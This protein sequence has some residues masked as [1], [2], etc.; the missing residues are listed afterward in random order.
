MS[1]PVEWGTEI[2]ASH[3]LVF[4]SSK[5]RLK[6]KWNRKQKVMTFL[7]GNYRTLALLG[8]SLLVSKIREE[9]RKKNSF[10]LF[11]DAKFYETCAFQK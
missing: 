10:R 4:S 1:L 5:E 6:K 9:G 2:H 11:P 8:L 7:P 3:V